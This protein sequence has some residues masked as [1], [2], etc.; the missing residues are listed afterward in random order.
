MKKISQK[1]LLAIAMFAVV[2]QACKNPAEGFIITVNSDISTN[3]FGF[4]VLNANPNLEEIPTNLTMKIVGPNADLVYSS[5]GSKNFSVGSVIFSL[6]LKPGIKPSQVNAIKFTVILE[7]NGYIKSI[8]PIEIIDE[9]SKSFDIFMVK[10][11]NPPVG[12]AVKEETI[13]LPSNGELAA[14]TIIEIPLN[15]GKQETAKL[16][17]LKG[18]KIFFKWK[19]M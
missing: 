4:R 7:S 5:D 6:I 16:E 19:L 18:T 14:T 11:D 10:K 12:V 8:T 9:G 17:I 3:N 13:V 1:I 15:N 2:I